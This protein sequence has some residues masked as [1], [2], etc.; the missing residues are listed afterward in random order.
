MD[1]RRTTMGGGAHDPK[2]QETNNR[3]ETENPAILRRESYGVLNYKT[4]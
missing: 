4:S 1:E 2:W 3:K